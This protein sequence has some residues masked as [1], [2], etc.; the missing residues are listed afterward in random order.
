MWKTNRFAVLLVGAALMAC[1]P[2]AQPTAGG[3]RL[4]RKPVSAE[5][6]SLRQQIA[7]MIMVRIEGHYYSAENEYHSDLVRW[8]GRDQVGGLITF[9]G[10]VDGTFTNLQ[11]L[12][13]LAPVPLL[14]A[15]DFERGVGQQIHGATRFPSNM[16]LA[17]TWNADNAYDQGRVT[18]LEARALGA[19][20]VF[21]PVMDVNNN[22]ANPIINFRSYSDDPALV[23]KMGSAFIR[24]AQE[25]GLIPCA[26][27]YP[28]H[29]NTATDSHTSLQVIPGQRSELDNME[30]MP[31]KTAVEAG[32]KMVMSGH[33]AVPGLDESGRPA[34]Q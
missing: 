14:V 23:A 11:E 16:A 31:F 7:Q 19:H 22:P 32:V 26:K 15:A 29:G 4:H 17:A 33:I 2:G 12:Q 9:R 20:V 28:G 6:L 24:G 27:H 5:D 21:A 25:H 34:S 30:L 10:S 3:P 8:V 13:R 1:T 18:A